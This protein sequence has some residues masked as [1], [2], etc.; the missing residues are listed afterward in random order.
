MTEWR[1]STLGDLCTSS[2]GSIQTG[3][4]GS[5]LH[6]SDY[7]NK[8]VP[9]VMPQDIGLN[10][11]LENQIVRIPESVFAGLSK[12]RLEPGDIVFSRRGEVDKCSLVR[13]ENDGWLCGTGCLRVRT[14]NNELVDPEFLSYLL[15]APK[16]RDW[17][18]THAV[19]ATMPN[20][21][22]SILASLPVRT[23][24]IR[25]QRAIAEV[26]GTLDYKIAANS[27][28]VATAAPLSASLLRQAVSTLGPREVAVGDI[29]ALVMRG[30]APAYVEDQGTW[31]I[32]QKC[33]R[34]R[35]VG[36]AD[37]RHTATSRVRADRFLN[38]AD[39][40]INSTGFG[41][42]GRV[43]RWTG[44]ESVTVDSHITIVRPDPSLIDPWVAGEALLGMQS[45][46]EAMAEGSTGQTELARGFVYAAPIELP[47]RSLEPE[48]GLKLSSL[49]DRADA[50]HYESQ[51]LSALRHTLLPELMSGRLRVKDAARQVEDVGLSGGTA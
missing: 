17:L 2:G 42:L 5:Q 29:A 34:G 31:V 21:N 1:I 18:R 11:I 27:Q 41:T 43:G 20:L 44:N 25:V 3:P 51:S 49:A 9:V 37:A 19:G 24:E 26:L 33:V 40:L 4:F 16:S 8:G 38:K 23:P 48:L 30:G 12:Y 28:I 7:A 50:A 32:N 45:S 6:A 13:G 35:R 39:V 36:L 10:V 47:Q 22:T 15:W 14:L 46:F